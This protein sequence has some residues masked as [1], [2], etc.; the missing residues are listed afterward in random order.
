MNK[1]IMNPQEK[2]KLQ[3]TRTEGNARLFGK[4]SPRLMDMFQSRLVQEDE[5]G[6]KN[7]TFPNV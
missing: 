3:E 4:G 5:K 7:D 1:V 6:Q 2:K